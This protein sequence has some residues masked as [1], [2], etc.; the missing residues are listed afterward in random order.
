MFADGSGVPMSGSVSTVQ[1]QPGTRGWWLVNP[2]EEDLLY[3]TPTK[4]A[5]EH[6]PVPVRCYHPRSLTSDRDYP[7]RA[8][9]ACALI[10]GA[11]M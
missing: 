6:K 8:S 5:L 1:V 2:T 4:A 11:S 9:Y 10:P 3:G 7:V